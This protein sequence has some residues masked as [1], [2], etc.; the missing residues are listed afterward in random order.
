MIK[1]AKLKKAL[2]IAGDVLLYFFLAL[3]IFMVIVTI[4]SKLG[5][6]KTGVS[7]VELFGYRMLVVTS[8][9]MEK[10]ELT[11][12]S[13]FEIKDI[14]LRSMVFVETVPEDPAKA[15]EWYS[16]IKVG[17]VLTIRY[18]YTSTVTITHRVTA[19][20]A[21]EGGYRIEL[22]GDNRTDETGMLYQVIDTS[23]P[24]VNF[25]VGRVV[26][27]N[28]PFG[29]F[30]NFIRQPI[31]MVLIVIVPCA[32][33]VVWE[34]IKIFRVLAADKKQRD[35]EERAQRDR[36]LDELRKKLAELEGQ[37]KDEKG[38]SE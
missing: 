26:A 28:R 22:A 35:A 16:Q 2:K 6:R 3:C 21:V 12:V 5:E 38:D 15:D 24:S 19:I 23:E 34:L 33:V 7:G 37:K 11:D 14:P 18:T 13:G 10:C 25:V 8:E 30:M 9:S 31:A 17:D 1:N 36:E 29:I 32:V 4:S 20:T 27:V